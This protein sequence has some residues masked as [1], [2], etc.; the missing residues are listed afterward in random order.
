M[1]KNISREKCFDL[2]KEYGTPSHVV[3]HCIAVS[4]VAVKIAEELNKKDFNLNVELIRGAALIHDIARVEDRHWETGSK[5]VA[6]MGYEEEADIIFHHMF[7]TIVDDISKISEIDM[8]CLGDR[9]VKE[10]K[11][12]GLD[13]RIK[14]VIEK[15]LTVGNNDTI[16]I[17]KRKTLITKRLISQIEEYIGITLDQ[18]FNSFWRIKVIFY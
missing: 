11:Y 8:V 10:D 15:A 18:L 16:E 4:E 13:V 5:I 3:K 9:L 14:Y 12:V 6:D 2:L 17:I 7:Y 1:D